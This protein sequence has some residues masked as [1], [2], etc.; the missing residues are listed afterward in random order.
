MAGAVFEG[1]ASHNHGPISFEDLNS[2]LENADFSTVDDTA[3]E[4]LAGD[5]DSD[6]ALIKSNARILP[7][8]KLIGNPGKWENSW[9]CLYT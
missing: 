8:G 1:F 9:E 6:Y 5:S 3:A 7:F 2:K 4:H